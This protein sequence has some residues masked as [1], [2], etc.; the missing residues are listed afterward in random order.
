MASVIELCI[1]SVQIT[2]I[3]LFQRIVEQ[4]RLPFHI[5]A[6]RGGKDVGVALYQYILCVGQEE[7]VL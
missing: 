3:E 4:L 7:E 6:D 2:V 1:W 5:K